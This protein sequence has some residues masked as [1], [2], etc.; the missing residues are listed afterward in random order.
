MTGARISETDA[1][2]LMASRGVVLPPAPPQPGGKRHFA[3]GRLPAGT[4]NRTEARY[5]AEVLEPAMQAKLVLWYAFE[6]V[7][8]RLAPNTFL[9][10]DFAVLPSTGVLE[11]IDV[12]GAAAMIEEDARVKLKVAASGFPF[13]FRIALPRPKRDGGGWMHEEVGR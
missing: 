3:L 9:T 8:L 10:V 6:G 7:K 2:R 11:M 1:R 13:V 5:A 4:M 12:K